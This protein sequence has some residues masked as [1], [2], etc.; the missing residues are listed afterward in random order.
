MSFEK[1]KIFDKFV[2]NISPLGTESEDL[3][4]SGSIEP[5]FCGSQHS[6]HQS[7]TSYSS[8]YKSKYEENVIKEQVFPEKKYFQKSKKHYAW[9][10]I[11]KLILI[12]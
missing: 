7:S 12:N 5:K 8:S 1:K 11:I 4:E 10:N 2:D 9:K 3:F 6:L